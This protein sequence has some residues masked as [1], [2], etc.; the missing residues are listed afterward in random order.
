MRACQ[1]NGQSP[2]GKRQISALVRAGLDKDVVLC[3]VKASERQ[4]PVHYQLLTHNIRT[5]VVTFAILT[6]SLSTLP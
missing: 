5:T 4:C 3:P 1:K 6:L 2:T